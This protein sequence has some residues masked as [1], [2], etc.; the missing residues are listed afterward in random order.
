MPKKLDVVSIGSSLRDI[1][2]INKDMKLRRS[3]IKDPFDPSVVGQKISL[4][5]IYFDIG[6]GGSN[7]AATFA[8]LG[9]DTALFSGVGND[10][11]GREIKRIMKEF[12][13]KTKL[14]QTIKKE[15]TGYSIIFLDKTGD[16]TALVYRGASD[17]KK[18]EIEKLKNTKSDWF[19]ITSLGGNLPLLQKIFAIAKKNKTQIAWNPGAKELS[20][21]Q[22]IMKKM[23]TQSDIIFLNKKETQDFLQSRVRSEAK[24]AR[25]WQK[26]FPRTIFCL[27]SGKNGAWVINGNEIYKADILDKKVVNATG[28]GDAFGSGFLSGVINYDNDI[29]KALRLAML[30]SNSVVTEMGAKHGLLKKM[31]SKKHLETI[32]ICCAK[33]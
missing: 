9:L 19:F 23:I 22:S 7:T 28:A 10:L 5:K 13:V 33:Q 32:K 25:I 31:P 20:A 8:S 14:I 11:P 17:S 15:E 12:G 6:G 21:R 29:K 18:W 1:F 3:R 30:N 24:L 4:D 16:R 27:T 2:V 26:K